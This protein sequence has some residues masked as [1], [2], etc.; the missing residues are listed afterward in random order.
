M[1]DLDG[2]LLVSAVILIAAILAARLGARI[3]LPSLLLFLALGMAM[4]PLGLNL[5][6]PDLARAL[7]FGA[8]VL[9]LAEGGLTTKW[10]DIKPSIGV[11][12]LFSPRS[13][14]PSAWP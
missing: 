2:I 10:S 4:G 9:I 6:D 12:S 13:A 1:I 11:A 3:G 8:L 5:N 7:G 14:S